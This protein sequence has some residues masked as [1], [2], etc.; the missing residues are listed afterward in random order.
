MTQKMLVALKGIQ[1][2][3]ILKQAI[4]LFGETFIRLTILS[5]FA[6]PFLCLTF[7]M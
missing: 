5:S 4:I 2:T 1:A 7:L 6:S 3:F